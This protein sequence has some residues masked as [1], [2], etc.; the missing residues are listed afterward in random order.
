MAAS[1]ASSQNTPIWIDVPFVKQSPDGCGAAALAMVMQYWE[2]QQ[3]EASGNASDAAQIMTTLQSRE[4]PGIHASAMSQYLK[5]HGFQTFSFAGTWEDL[6]DHLQKGRPLIVALG[7][8][9]SANLM[10]YV[11]ITGVDPAAGLV[12][13]N[14]PA[15]RKLSKLD[16]KSFEKEWNASGKWT[17][18]ALPQKPGS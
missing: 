6:L 2:R 5:D 4:G 17:L 10:H 18:L 8:S 15:G 1:I 7:R 13:F 11:V 16:R 3:G 12:M 14:D 9:K